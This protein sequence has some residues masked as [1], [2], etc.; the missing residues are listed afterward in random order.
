[1]QV[2]LGERRMMVALAMV[3]IDD[4]E[5]EGSVRRSVRS[6][7]MKEWPIERN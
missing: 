7:A 3:M 5:H 1:M 4:G 6:E 2:G